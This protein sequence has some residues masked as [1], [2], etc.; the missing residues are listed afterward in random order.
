MDVDSEME[1]LMMDLE[2]IAELRIIPLRVGAELMEA[3]IERVDFC[4]QGFLLLMRRLGKLRRW[5]VE[6][7][8]VQ[9]LGKFIIGCEVT[10]LPLVFR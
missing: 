6:G 5:G 1:A 9:R 8:A 3:K 2:K 10:S 7:T 4:R